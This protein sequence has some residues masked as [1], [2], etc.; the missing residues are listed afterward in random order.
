MFKIRSDY[1]YGDGGQP[2]SIPPKATLIF[3][4]E[5]IDWEAEDISPDKDKTILKTCIVDGEKLANP[6]DTSPVTGI[7][8]FKLKI[9]F[10]VF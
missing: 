3:D 2:P 4:V 5:L 10:I 6:S 9:M 1:A 8:L 7:C